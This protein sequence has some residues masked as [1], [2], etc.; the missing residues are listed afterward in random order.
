[1]TKF[2]EIIFTLRKENGFTQE[3]IAIKLNVSRQTISNWET[4]TAQPTID[5][6]SELSDIY[7]VSLDQLIGRNRIK[8]KKVSPILTDLLN[9]K[10]TLYLKP[11]TETWISVSRIQFK[12]CLVTEIKETSI[13]VTITEKKQTVEKLIFLKDILGLE[14]EEQ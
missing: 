11:N 10:V 2:N 3:E 14:K 8:E 13:R 5:K 9:Q 1:M 7:D 12:N 4:G 6:V